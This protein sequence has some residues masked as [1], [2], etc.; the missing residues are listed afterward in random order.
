[1]D[2]LDKESIIMIMESNGIIH[3]SNVTIEFL[4]KQEEESNKAISLHRTIGAYGLPLGIMGLR[5]RSV[6][7][8]WQPDVIW[9]HLD[10]TRETEEFIV[11]QFGDRPSPG[12]YDTSR[13]LKYCRRARIL[14]G[15]AVMI[16][17]EGTQFSMYHYAGVGSKNTGVE[18][19][20]IVQHSQAYQG[21]WG[22]EQPPLDLTDRIKETFRRLWFNYSYDMTGFDKR[23]KQVSLEKGFILDNQSGDYITPL[24]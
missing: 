6:Y 24:S 1:M 21:M 13:Y 19:G 11:K 18:E 20:I 12:N 2:Y 17:V 16:A 4:E 5:L 23:I 7:R 22:N 9:L 15:L 10:I 8:L 3:D 14:A